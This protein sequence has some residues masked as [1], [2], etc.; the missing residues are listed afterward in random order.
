M[1]LSYHY[2]S[3]KK[4]F[5][6]IDGK[7]ALAFFKQYPAPQTLKGVTLSELT[8]F[9][10]EASNNAVSKRKAKGILSLI[11]AD[12][13]TK[14]EYQD[15]RDFL[16]QSIVRD[17]QFKKQGIA[18]LEEELRVLMDKLDYKLDTMPGIDLVTSSAVVAEIGD[19]TRFPNPDKLARFAGIAPVHFSSGGKG[20]DKKSEQGNRTLHGLFYF[21]AVQQVQVSKGSKIPRN[22]VFHDYYQRKIKEGKTKGQALVYIM[23][24]LVYSM[25]PTMKKRRGR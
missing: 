6:E 15:H 16:V 13:D 17:I 10:L 23:R 20:K 12:G 1:Q 14:R 11:T 3:Y 25:P 9:L 5:S 7:T 18:Y 21:L 24:R 22:P 8:A 4:F 2:P 19:I